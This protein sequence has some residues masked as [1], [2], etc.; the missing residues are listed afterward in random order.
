MLRQS[1]KLK[2]AGDVV[3]AGCAG[4]DVGSIDEL[5]RVL[6]VHRQDCADGNRAVGCQ[7]PFC[8]TWSEASGSTFATGQPSL[9]FLAWYE[10]RGL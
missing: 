7:V 8:R 4:G 9:R 2:L 1:P 6:R 3:S 10:V 5:C